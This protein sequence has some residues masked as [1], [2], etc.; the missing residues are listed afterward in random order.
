MGLESKM[1]LFEAWYSEI[2]DLGN[3]FIFLWIPNPLKNI[4]T[5]L[6][7]YSRKYTLQQNKDRLYISKAIN[8][9]DAQ[10]REYDTKHV[11]QYY[12]PEKDIKKI[13]RLEIMSDLV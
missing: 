11:N 6:L 13:E 10:L 1:E 8:K 4:L 7:T 3:Y 12:L 5:L 2:A 9:F